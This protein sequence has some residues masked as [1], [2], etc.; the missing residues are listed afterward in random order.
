MKAIKFPDPTP[1]RK[2]ARQLLGVL[3][4]VLFVLWAL[5]MLLTTAPTPTTDELSLKRSEPSPGQLPPHLVKLFQEGLDARD[6]EK[7]KCPY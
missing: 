3:F 6:N 7:P 2:A 5:W 4:I 1:R